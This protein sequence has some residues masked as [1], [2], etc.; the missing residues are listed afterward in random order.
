MDPSR[1]ATSASTD[2]LN[3]VMVPSRV[4]TS[5]SILLSRAA[6]VLARSESVASISP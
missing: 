2:A 1:V 5:L 6:D 4:E 3:E